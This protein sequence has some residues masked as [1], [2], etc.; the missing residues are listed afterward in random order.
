[1]NQS[2][3]IVNFNKLGDIFQSAHLMSS[4]KQKSPMTRIHYVCYEEC[5]S[6]ARILKDI[7]QIHSVP[8][9]KITSFI[10]NKLY[11]DGLAFN[12]LQKSLSEL[13][14]SKNDQ[15]INYSN[16]K[17]GTYICSYLSTKT[18]ALVNG[19]KFSDS[20]IVEYSS[21][22][23]IIINDIL[24]VFKAS[25]Y[26]FNNA[27]H[28]LTQAPYNKVRDAVVIDQKH[29]KLAQESIL[30]LRCSKGLDPKNVKIIGIQI[31]SAIPEKDIPLD[32]IISFI[33]LCLQEENLIPLLLVAPTKIEKDKSDLINSYFDSKLVSVES[34]FKALPS[35]LSN[36][37]LLVTPDTSVK[38]LADLLA[39]KVV[40]VSL[41][42]APVLKQ[43]S[44][45]TESLVLT[46]EPSVRIFKQDD[47]TTS[48][49]VE[50]NKILSGQ[51]IFHTSL[52]L[53]SNDSKYSDYEISP[54]VICYQAIKTGDGLYHLPIKGNINVTFELR[55]IVSRSVI[56]K[57]IYNTTDKHFL[58]KVLGV[59]N[60]DD[61]TS[62]IEQE[63]KSLA[64]TTKDL[65]GTLRELV[66]L[67]ESTKN[68][69]GFIDALEKLFT[70]CHQPNISA[71]SVLIFRAKVETI[72][73]TSIEDNLREVE[74]LIYQLKN[75]IQSS[76]S[77][78]SDCQEI[79]IG[80]RVQ[81]ENSNR[82]LNS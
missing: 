25:P 6:A 75:D 52:S 32:S 63:K 58:T 78:M 44:N 24:P 64:D 19:I 17:F 18:G 70:K 14:L 33:Q 22:H 73:S 61:I 65:L 43:G 39:T 49:V 80:N 40:E 23:S 76:L 79:S 55:R 46:R 29:Q 13:K 71:L 26:N 30:K 69:Q 41:G 72:K 36:I 82:E 8:R 56:Q 28:A 48:K 35:V 3:V 20:N 53:L 15:V 12:T 31:A 74:S 2:I 68:H 4:I 60:K 10:K 7:D 67:Q 77:V 47:M 16:D 21:N 51:D 45:N 57:I 81:T 27:Y 42:P 54:G 59:F 38:H 37:D 66:R 34:D 1:M 11:S 5:V 62:F 9:K 50:E